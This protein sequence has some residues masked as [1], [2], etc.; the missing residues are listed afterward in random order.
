MMLAFDVDFDFDFHSWGPNLF[1]QIDIN[2]A[3]EKLP[4]IWTLRKL[5]PIF[6]SLSF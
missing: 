3:A 5:L 4:D 1:C 2:L 6:F